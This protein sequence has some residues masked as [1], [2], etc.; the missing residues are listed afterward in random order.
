MAEKAYQYIRF[1]KI[2]KTWQATR[3]ILRS[4][5]FLERLG[6][7]MMK[8]LHFCPNVKFLVAHQKTLCYNIHNGKSQFVPTVLFVAARGMPM[9]AG[10]ALLTA[11]GTTPATPTPTWVFGL[12]SI[13]VS[14]VRICSRIYPGFPTWPDFYRGQVLLGQRKKKIGWLVA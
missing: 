13:H 10:C 9:P 1:T 8:I 14:I 6:S 4:R 11:T 5:I 2:K 12:L 7:M 3:I